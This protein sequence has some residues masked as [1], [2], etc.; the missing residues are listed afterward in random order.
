MHLCRPPWVGCKVWCKVRL[1]GMECKIMHKPPVFYALIQVKFNPV[2][3]DR[4]VQDFREAIRPEF[5]DYEGDSQTEIFISMG[6]NAKPP[7]QRPRNRWR[8][9]NM[10]R[11]EGF[12]LLDDALVYHTNRYDCFTRC[13]D[14]TLQ[15]LDVLHEQVKLAYVERIGMRY[16][17]I[18][19]DYCVVGWLADIAG[20][21]CPMP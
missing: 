6:P 1:L 3:M 2:Q 19:L 7:E 4:F 5:P 16:D 11:T 14:A 17:A 20:R 9:L 12:T 21:R 18:N 13:R 15:A 10:D 8:F